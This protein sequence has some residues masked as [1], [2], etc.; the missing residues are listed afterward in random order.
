MIG[1]YSYGEEKVQN[2]DYSLF[3]T[4]QLPVEPFKKDLDIQS[5]IIDKIECNY[6]DNWRNK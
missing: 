2:I 4:L 6:N 5:D 1:V 3:Y